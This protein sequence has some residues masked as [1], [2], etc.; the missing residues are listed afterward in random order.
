V[1]LG[2]A[3]VDQDGAAIRGRG[4]DHVARL[5]V[6]VDDCGRLAVEVVEDLG[7]LPH[8]VQDRRPRQ[9]GIAPLAQQPIQRRPIDPVHDQVVAIAEDEVLAD[10]AG[11]RVGR[12]TQQDARLV[13]DVAAAGD[14]VGI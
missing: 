8:P 5:H 13:E 4:E 1:V 12:H 11:M 9:A 10:D 14:V 3:K 7:D 2:D 6:A